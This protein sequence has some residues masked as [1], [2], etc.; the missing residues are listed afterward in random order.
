MKQV[1]C[2]AISSLLILVPWTI[3]PLRSNAWAP[4]SPAAQIIVFLYAL[5]MILGGVFTGVSYKKLLVRNM[6]MKIC[7]V[8]HMTYAMFGAAAILLMSL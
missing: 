1:V 5:E 3:F 2:T 8:I 6:I 4:E 7:L